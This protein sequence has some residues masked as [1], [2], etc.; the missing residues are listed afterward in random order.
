LKELELRERSNILA[1]M[2]ATLDVT[3]KGE[4]VFKP[5]LAGVYGGVIKFI[6]VP[7][8][9]ALILAERF[10]ICRLLWFGAMILLT[11]HYLFKLI[12]PRRYVREKELMAMSCM[13]I[14]TIYTPIPLVLG[15]LEASIL[16]FVGVAY[17]FAMNRLLWQ[18][19]Y[20]RV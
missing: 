14:V 12:K 2:G 19:P 16:M 9:G 17:F 15:W 11:S 7:I 4:K 1:R 18:K 10:D 13:E 20:P 5:G 3:W 6:N 8:L